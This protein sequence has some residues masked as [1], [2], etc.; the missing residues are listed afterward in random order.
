MHP[1]DTY[2][3]RGIN[4][5]GA[6][7]EYPFTPGW[8]GAGVVLKA[9]S[10]DPALNSLVGKRVAFVKGKDPEPGV[11]TVGGAYA[12]YIATNFTSCVPLPEHISNEEGCAFYVNPLTAMGMVNRAKELGAKAIILTAAA[13]QLCKMIIRI[14]ETEERKMDVICHVR[15]QE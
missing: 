7:K 10:D 15:R 14:C 6:P 5:F 3:M 13:A 2:F 4:L 8:E 9:G 11:M 12:E 1:S